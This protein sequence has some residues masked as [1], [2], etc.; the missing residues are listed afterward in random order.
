M[1][2][3]KCGYDLRASNDHC[4]EC[5]RFFDRQKSNTY[6]MHAPHL[7]FWSWVKRVLATVVL[8]FVLL[9]SIWLWLYQGW[10][11]EQKSLKELEPWIVETKTYPIGGE[12]WQRRLGS[13]GFV[14]N[15][16]TEVGIR[17]EAPLTTTDMTSL[18]QFKQL[19]ELWIGGTGVNDEGLANLEELTDLRVLILL[20]DRKITDAGLGHLK[21]LKKLEWLDLQGTQVTDAG[22][23]NLKEL[24]KLQRL[25]LSG[26][27]ITDAGVSQLKRLPDLQHLKLS[28]TSVLGT[29]LAD[30]K[31]LRVLYMDGTA[32][33]DA[34]LVP[35]ARL[36]ELREFYIWNTAVTDTGLMQLQSLKNL[37]HLNVSGTQVTE[38]GAKELQALLPDLFIQR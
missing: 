26:T 16:V 8:I 9:G 19:Q 37:R 12:K 11:R 35:I 36:Q 21:R 29:T 22:L 15:R 27:K 31:D 18:G 3:K 20:S 25:S 7:A 33:R 13:V 32:I 34:N 5:G 14:L 38:P 6:S 30:L 10:R 24:N 17:N 28:G 4:P 1:Y 23:E 2:C